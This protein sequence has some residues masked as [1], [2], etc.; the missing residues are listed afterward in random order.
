MPSLPYW[1]LPKAT[2][3]YDHVIFDTA[4][5]GHTLR[6]LALPAAW[7]GFIDTNTSGTSCLGPLAGLQDQ[8]DLYAASVQA[9]SDPQ[10]TTLVLVSRP[11]ATALAEAERTRDELAGA[12]MRRQLLALNGVFDAADS[13]DPTALALARVRPPRSPACPPRSRSSSASR[14]RC[15]TSRRSGPT[16]SPACSTTRTPPALTRTRTRSTC[17]ARRCPS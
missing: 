2:A 3:N 1:A 4:P 5:T 12:G 8:R 17:P 15:W 10:T 11:E 13:D 6:L 9:L 16:R 7:T 14:S